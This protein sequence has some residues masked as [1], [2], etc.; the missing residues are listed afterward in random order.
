VDTRER[1]STIS[2]R[3]LHCVGNHT[4]RRGGWPI[5]NDPAQPPQSGRP[6]PTCCAKRTQSAPASGTRISKCQTNPIRP[7]RAEANIEMS[8][9]PNFPLFGAK[10]RIEPE[11]QSQTKPKGRGAAGKGI[12]HP[13]SD[14]AGPIAR[15]RRSAPPCRAKR[16]QFAPAGKHET[17]ISKCQTNPIA[18]LRPQTHIEKPNK[19]NFPLFGPKT[20]VEAEEQSQTKPNRRKARCTI[21]AK[22]TQYPNDRKALVRNEKCG[23]GMAAGGRRGAGSEWRTGAG[24]RVSGIRRWCR[25]RRC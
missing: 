6:A 9:K 10:T 21:S 18:T 15:A 4:T 24:G 25:L 14:G 23:C 3:I 16:T 12:E 1:G 13:G 22:R 20:R 11:K 2:A 7:L 19:A 8:N 17:R 5:G